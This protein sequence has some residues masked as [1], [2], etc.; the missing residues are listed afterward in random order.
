MVRGRVTRAACAGC[1]ALAS[2][3]ARAGEFADA[4]AAYAPA[5][6][7]FVNT[8]AY[9]DPARALGAPVGGGTLAGDT[10][11]VVTLGG[12]GG[13]ITLRFSTP[14]LDDPCNPFG[15]DLVVFG[16]AFWVSGNANRR[17]AEAAV[18]EV[19]RDENG[20]GLA[21][22][23]WFVMPGSHGP[24]PI[25]SQAWDNDAGTPTPPANL[26]WYPAGA[27]G[28]MTTMGVALPA[29]FDTQVLQNPNGPGATSEGVWGYADCSPTL[30]LG[31]LNGDNVVEA[32]SMSAGEFYTSPDNPRA[33]G[34]TPGSGGGDAFDLA[35]AIDP[36]TGRPARPAAIDFVRIT[37]GVNHV[38]GA[39]GE[40]SAEIAAVSDVRP[41]EGFFD[42][43]GDGRADAEDLHRWHALRA[44]GDAAADVDGDGVIGEGDRSMLTRCVRREE[45]TP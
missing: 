30:L 21:D 45:W 43:T 22:D 19:S 39:L 17:W 42:R 20:N 9:N 27:P 31:D 40:V 26:A 5:P 16:N 7:Q 18:V 37:N 10:S 15:L 35:W 3:G 4:V 14:V 29:L 34:V 2:S 11:K 44:A 32:P 8:A 25:E 28:T 33:V 12:F 1:V 13:S 6:G 36:A 23:A 38:A 24:L 41:R